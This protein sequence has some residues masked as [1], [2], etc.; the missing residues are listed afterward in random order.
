M[1]FSKHPRKLWVAAS[2][3]DVASVT[4]RLD[5]GDSINAREP[6]VGSSMPLCDHYYIISGGMRSLKGQRYIL[7]S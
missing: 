3:G 5:E 7:P 2:Q 1:S 4:K 6:N